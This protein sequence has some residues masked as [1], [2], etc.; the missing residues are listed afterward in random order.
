MKLSR[1]LTILRNELDDNPLSESTR[2]WSDV[3]LA[4]YLDEGIIKFCEETRI[5]RDSATVG[6]TLS[7]ATVTLTGTSGQ[8]D[9]VTVND[10]T[11]TSAAVAFDS[12]LPTTATN[13]ASN[14]NANTSSP[15]Y[16]ADASAGDGSLII[17]AVAG[18]GG[19]P[20]GY[21]VVTTCSGGDL[22]ADD[23]EMADGTSLCELYLLAERAAYPTD[24]RIV[25]IERVSPSDRPILKKRSQIWMDENIPDWE[26]AS[27][28][29]PE[30]FIT[31]ISPDS[32]TFYPKPDT[33]E[34]VTCTIARQPL[35]SMMVDEYTPYYA[36]DIELRDIDLE[37]VRYWARRCAFLKEDAET[38]RP[39]KAE[40]FENKYDETVERK[41]RRMT[42]SQDINDSMQPD[43]GNL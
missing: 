43:L 8:V 22:A 20:N 42:L 37:G 2:L 35:T 23:S 1:L 4:E 32:I 38:L 11:I 29:T 13:L 19:N 6:E 7:T 15:N 16:T 31:D 12:D 26:Y 9:S 28:G 5:L 17:S 27:S 10:V 33:A 39:Q 41:K 3:E 40:Y 34:T 21:D 14:I 36:L 18:T 30:I 24:S 25:Q